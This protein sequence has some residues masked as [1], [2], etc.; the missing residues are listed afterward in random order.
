MITYEDD[1]KFIQ[2]IINLCF[3]DSKSIK[4]FLTTYVMP[5]ITVSQVIS[6]DFKY[7]AIITWNQKAREPIS[8]ADP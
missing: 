1:T 5:Y 7:E 8:M 4:T 2:T 6:A 3:G